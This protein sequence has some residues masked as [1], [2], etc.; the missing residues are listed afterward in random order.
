M[1]SIIESLEK[2]G[3]FKTFREVIRKVGLEKKLS[4][5]GPFTVFAP[6]DEAFGKIPS[7]NLQTILDD[8]QMLSHVAEYHVVKG[9]FSSEDLKNQKREFLET[10]E[11]SR[12]II[13][14][15]PDE[16][17]QVDEAKIVQPDVECSN[18]IC[19]GVD[20]VLMPTLSQAFQAYAR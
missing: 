20:S 12:V 16:K 19:H 6:T 13:Y 15:S 14:I 18:G 5:E 3:N 2:A 10:V 4:G 1:E 8:S 11:G 9:R 17:V 7:E